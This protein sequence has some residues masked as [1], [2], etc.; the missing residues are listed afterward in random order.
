MLAGYLKE[1]F[2][3]IVQSTNF[4]NMELKVAHEE[5][6]F[7]CSGS[8]VDPEF[9]NMFS[10]TFLNGDPTTALSRPNSI[11]ISKSLSLR[12]FGNK[13]PAGKT[14]EINDANNY[15][16]SGII[17][18]IP[19]NSHIQFDFLMPF[20][21]ADDWM[22]TWNAKW[23]NTYIML[24][25]NSRPEEVNKKISGVMNL[26]QPSWGNILYL[27]PVIK[28]HLYA[29]R[30]R[31]LIAYVLIFSAMAIIIILLACVNFMN[32]STARFELRQK[33]IFIKKI[34][35]SKR[36][37]LAVQFLSE[38]VF[39]T[40]IAFII[41]MILVELLLPSINNLLHTSLEIKYNF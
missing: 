15:S 17:E 35:G 37:Q 41:A 3:E 10:L 22:K 16:I 31:G 5:T 20:S 13:N 8:Y 26:F 38:S 25:E 21:D 14:L 30:G 7:Y 2:P 9:F 29:L 4:S 33:E 11:V 23:T 34:S 39:L 36:W 24:Q 18:D 28:S 19:E 32:L 27:V 1:N 40:F 12:L 6:G